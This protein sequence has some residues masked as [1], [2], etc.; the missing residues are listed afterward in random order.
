MKYGRIIPLEISPR[1]NTFE[2]TMLDVG[3]LNECE[4]NLENKQNDA[5]YFISNMYIY[6]GQSYKVDLQQWIENNQTLN[7]NIQ[8]LDLPITSTLFN[9]VQ[10]SKQ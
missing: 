5:A 10:L 2:L 8:L 3:L 4:I 9:K 7:S 6:R 1:P